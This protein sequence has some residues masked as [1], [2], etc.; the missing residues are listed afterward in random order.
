M[1][2]RPSAPLDPYLDHILDL[3]DMRRGE[4]C[5]RFEQQGRRH[6]SKREAFLVRL[7]REAPSYQANTDILH[8][9]QQ[10]VALIPSRHTNPSL[11]CKKGV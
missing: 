8:F 10:A 2:L 1:M 9:K 4:I 7:H 6:T 5:F 11:W 3:G